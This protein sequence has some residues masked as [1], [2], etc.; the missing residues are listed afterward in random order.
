MAGASYRPDS[1]YLSARRLALRTASG[2]RAEGP[3]G[4]QRDPGCEHRLGSP[5]GISVID[6]DSH[7]NQCT[8]CNRNGGFDA[9]DTI[10]L[11]RSDIG[12]EPVARARVLEIDRVRI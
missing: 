6:L 8:A 9:C 2:P 7:A 11:V 4:N 12:D 5:S 10:Q 1:D 3:N